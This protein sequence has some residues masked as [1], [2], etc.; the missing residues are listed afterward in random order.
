MKYVT[1][2]SNLDFG[3]A[4][5]DDAIDELFLSSVPQP[6]LDWFLMVFVRRHPRFLVLVANV[7]VH[8]LNALYLLETN[9]RN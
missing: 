3:E 5:S 1:I 8:V 9:A 7:Q 2:F 4:V 6:P